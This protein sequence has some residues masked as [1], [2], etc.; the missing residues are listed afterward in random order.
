[1]L[2][3]TLLLLVFDKNSTDASGLVLG[4]GQAWPVRTRPKKGGH[5]GGQTGGQTGGQ[6]F[7]PPSWPAKCTA[8]LKTGGH[9]GG[10]TGGQNF[11]PP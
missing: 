10:Q 6:K 2:D 1:M 4:G 8:K 11:G 5:F 3:N 7:G 9:F